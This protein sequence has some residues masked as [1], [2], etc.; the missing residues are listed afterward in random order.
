M[1]ATE[2]PVVLVTGSRKGLGRGLVESYLQRGCRVYGCSRRPSDLNDANYTHFELDVGNE[3]AVVAMIRQIDREA[4]RIDWVINNAGIA[5]M[6]ALMLCPKRSVERV[7]DTN[8][9]GTFLV[10]REAGKLMMRRHIHGRMVNISSVA[11]P[12][13]LEGEAAYAASKAAIETLTRIAAHEFGSQGITVNAVGP[14]PV[15]TDLLHGVGPEKLERLVARQAI[16]RMGTINDVINAVDF[17]TSPSSSFITGQVIYLG[18]VC[19][20]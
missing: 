7:L 1:N 3:Q 6:N 12:L 19:G 5:S 10:L 13:N 2:D 15:D 16:R 9:I 8:F 17:F 11:V 18:G 4:G 20:N 14:T